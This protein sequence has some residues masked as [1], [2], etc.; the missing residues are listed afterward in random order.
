M[1]ETFRE[2]WETSEYSNILTDSKRMPKE[3][4]SCLELLRGP[5]EPP[6]KDITEIDETETSASEHMDVDEVEMRSIPRIQYKP[7]QEEPQ[8]LRRSS[9]GPSRTSTSAPSVT[10]TMARRR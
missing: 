1:T 10:S 9:S 3:I 2:F 5:I 4:V 8:W 7:N 6:T